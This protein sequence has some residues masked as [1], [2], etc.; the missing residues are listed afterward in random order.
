MQTI[1][2]VTAV[3]DNEARVVETEEQ[4]VVFD[5][6]NEVYGVDIGRVQEI[7]RMATIG[8]SRSWTAA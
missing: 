4:L 6:A 8:G 2:K 7:I 5:L 3:A 1:Q